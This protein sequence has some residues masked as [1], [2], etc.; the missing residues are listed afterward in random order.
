M[1]QNS[2]SLLFTLLYLA[3]GA[4]CLYTWVRLRFGGGLYNSPL[5][6]PQGLTVSDCL[7]PEGYVRY[8]SPCVLILGLVVF[9]AAAAD[10]FS[11]AFLP[12]PDWVSIVTIVL[13]FGVLIWYA[14][15]FHRAQSRYW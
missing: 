1:D 10:L 9:L 7:D 3:C 8:I 15:W 13:P 2:F 12:L 6:I 4:Y 14:V 5:L 11:T